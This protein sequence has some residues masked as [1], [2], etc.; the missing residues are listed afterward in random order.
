[1]AIR[2]VYL[3]LFLT[4]FLLSSCGSSSSSGKK[5]W[6]YEYRPG[7]TAIVVSGKAV[8]PAGLPAPVMR[9]INAGNNIAGR[10][11]KFGGGHRVLEDTGYDCS[12]TVCYA[13]QH[14][15]LIKSCGTSDSL[16]SFGKKGEGKHITVYSRKGH[17]F[18]VIAGLRLDTGYNGQNDGPK[19][20]T[21]SR[22]LKGYVARHPAGM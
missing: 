3:L 15:G 10:P 17:A 7:K 12:G 13:L 11:Y 16:R 20:S 22:P 8:P 4:T 1:M 5:R 19:W 18:V 14:A 6:A 2:A 9:A 21:N